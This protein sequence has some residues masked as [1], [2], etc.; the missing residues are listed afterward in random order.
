MKRFALCQI[1]L[2]H[3]GC[4]E[5]A[6]KG[7]PERNQFSLEASYMRKTKGRGHVVSVVPKSTGSLHGVAQSSTGKTPIEFELVGNDPGR[8][9]KVGIVGANRAVR[10]WNNHAIRPSPCQARE[11]EISSGLVFPHRLGSLSLSTVPPSVLRSFHSWCYKSLFKR[12]GSACG[13]ASGVMGHCC[14]AITGTTIRFV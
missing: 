4:A 3:R 11:R 6:G 13:V 9:R 7:K 14:P 1:F 10:E 5:L 2:L 8:L 12:S